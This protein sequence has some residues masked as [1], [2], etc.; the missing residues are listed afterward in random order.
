MLLRRLRLELMKAETARPGREC[1]A[2]AGNG[3]LGPARAGRAR[4]PRGGA[5]RGAEPRHGRRAAPAG[6][7]HPQAGTGHGGSGKLCPVQTMGNS[8]VV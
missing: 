2:D 1:C 7:A 4:R 6:R 3:G 5:G 8:V